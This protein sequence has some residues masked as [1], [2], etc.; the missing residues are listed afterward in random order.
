MAPPSIIPT[1]NFTMAGTEP[2]ARSQWREIG[3]AEARG[4]GNG[5]GWGRGREALYRGESA[6]ASRPG[7]RVRVFEQP[8]P[9]TG[10]SKDFGLEKHGE[11]NGEATQHSEHG[12]ADFFSASQPRDHVEKKDN[13]QRRH[14][15][16]RRGGSACG[17]GGGSGGSAG[18]TE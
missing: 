18:P 3:G 15:P 5:E 2:T 12:Q 1:D 6:A 16:L 9:L 10:L 4:V 17:S 13:R 14:P 7:G 8:L 11:E